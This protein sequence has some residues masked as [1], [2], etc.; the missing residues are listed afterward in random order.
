R[1][2][3]TGFVVA[4][5][6]GADDADVSHWAAVAP[7]GLTIARDMSTASA[8]DTASRLLGHSAAP[9]LPIGIVVTAG[10]ADSTSYA[11]TLG[12]LAA[13]AVDFVDGPAVILVGRAVAH[14][15]WANAAA[16][17]ATSFK[18]A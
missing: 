7:S 17:A 18:V 16:V 3:S 2:V 10:R 5:A 13:G 8:A 14:G 6:H 15:D 9:G 11:G 4:T 1:N 12:G